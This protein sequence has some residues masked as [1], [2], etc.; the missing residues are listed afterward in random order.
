MNSI[1]VNSD[2]FAFGSPQELSA[3]AVGDHQ[4][5]LLIFLRQ[6]DEAQHLAFLTKILSAIK[7]QL[8]QDCCR[9]V[10]ADHHQLAIHSVP[11]LADARHILLFGISP[12]QLGLQFECPFYEPITIAQRTYLQSH[13]LESLQAPEHKAWK[14]ALWQCLQQIFLPKP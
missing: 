9:Y 10:L 8:D 12:Q 2:I 4:K 6:A 14:V 1:I 13:S 7:Y 5:G 3:H 11:Q